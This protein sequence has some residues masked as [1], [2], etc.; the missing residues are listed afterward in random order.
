MRNIIKYL[1]LALTMV[2]SSASATPTLFFDGAIKY[3]GAFG[4]LAVNAALTA[5]DDLAMAPSLA[6][7]TVDFSALF[8]YADASNAAYTVGY[9]GTTSTTDLKILDGSSNVLLSGNFTQLSF[10]GINN[11]NSGGLTGTFVATGGSLQSEFSNNMLFALGFNLDDV[12]SSSLFRT[13]ILTGRIDG[14]ITGESISVPEPATSAILALGLLFIGFVSRK[15]VRHQL[16][17][18]S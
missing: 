9:F 5:T 16:F 2:V 4:L 15:S 18:K 8:D 17:V 12:F 7:S 3:E 13:Q 14:R 11:S 1:G 10:A 6:G